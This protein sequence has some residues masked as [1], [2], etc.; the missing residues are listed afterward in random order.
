MTQF[1]GMGRDVVAAGSPAPLR[2]TR[3]LSLQLVQPLV[4]RVHAG[5]GGGDTALGSRAQQIAQLGSLLL[6][7]N[8]PGWGGCLL[9]RGRSISPGL[10]PFL[11]HGGRGGLGALGGYFHG[12]A[13]E[14]PEDGVTHPGCVQGSVCGGGHG[15]LQLEAG[16]RQGRGLGLPALVCVSCCD[17]GMDQE[18]SRLAAWVC[19]LEEGTRQEDLCW[20]GSLPRG[21]QSHRGF[22][23][24]TLVPHKQLH[25][26]Q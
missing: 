23:G 17:G 14:L 15:G 6:S 13:Q 21:A 11:E 7:G 12:G 22:P 20:G 8:E 4:P 10:L 25:L 2:I 16:R 5:S 24:T 9:H 18:P 19:F 1:A 3:S 26:W